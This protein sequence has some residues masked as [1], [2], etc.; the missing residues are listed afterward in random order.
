MSAPTAGERVLWTEKI[1]R[2]LLDPSA[3]DQGQ[4]VEVL[5]KLHYRLHGP[6]LDIVRHMVTGPDGPN[7]AYCLWALQL[8]GAANSRDHLVLNLS[9]AKPELRKGAAGV[10]RLMGSADEGALAALALAADREPAESMAYPGVLSSAITL[11]PNHPQAAAWQAKLDRLFFTGLPRERLDAGYGLMTVYDVADLP[12]LAPLLDDAHDDIRTIAAWTILKVAARSHLL[13]VWIGT[14]TDT[15]GR[16]IYAVQF[17]PETGTLSPASL[18]AAAS[19]PSI[20]IVDPSG[21]HLYAGNGTH[22][23]MSAYAIGHAG[24]LAPINSD[25]AV[26]GGMIS[27]FGMDVAGRQLVIAGNKGEHAFVYAYA[28]QP[29]GSL[30]AHTAPIEQRGPPGPIRP[31]QAHPHA[32]SIAISPDG[33][34]ALACDRGI[35]RIFTY[36]IDPA[37]GKVGPEDPPYFITAPGF[38]PRHSVFSPDGRY[39][40]VIGEMSGKVAT[41]AYN[42]ADGSLA[43]RDT[44]SA[45]APG[46]S[47]E[48]QSSEIALGPGGRQL[49][50]SNRGSGS[51]SLTVFQRD[52]ASGALQ[53]SQIIACGGKT[54]RNFALSPDGRWLVCANQDS[55]TLV[56][57]RIDPADGRL[58]RMPGQV[59]VPHPSCVV[60]SP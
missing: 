20:L 10:L 15:T 12:R 34:F 2:V 51:D 48:N 13:Q 16:G 44:V 5:A 59:A 25:P 31:A 37:A 43:L 45:M 46:F 18:A 42:A 22:G 55:D 14:Y 29:D 58:T 1:K 23:G 28:L 41:F 7:T 60:F 11:E 50:V 49:Y 39:F 47:G 26:P 40:Y 27:H 52:A 8:A 21:R 36:R 54:P 32:H 35:D 17:D 57:F 38:G 6:A 53:Q 56:V 19:N 24:R 4:A 33:R 30:G 3:P 9:S